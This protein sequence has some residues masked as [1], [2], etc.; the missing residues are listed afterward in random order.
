MI[1]SSLSFLCVGWAV[2]P[3]LTQSIVFTIF[4]VP[5][6]FVWYTFTV[7]IYNRFKFEF[8]TDLNLHTDSRNPLYRHDRD[9]T[10]DI[11]D[12]IDETRPS[13]GVN[14]NFGHSKGIDKKKSNESKTPSSTVNSSNDGSAHSQVS[15]SG[16]LSFLS[17]LLLKEEKESNSGA[18][19]TAEDVVNTLQSNVFSGYIS[20][21]DS[22]TALSSDPWKR[23]YTRLEK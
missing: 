18:T 11:K 15:H 9:D 3:T 1:W 20:I 6:Y 7:R 8:T 21:K 13:I 19:S 4:T 14:Y 12:R 5:G 22:Q 16:F 23:R 2:I 17:R 10:I